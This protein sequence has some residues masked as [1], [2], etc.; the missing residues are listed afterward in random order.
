MSVGEFVGGEYVGRPGALIN[1]CLFKDMDA[2]SRQYFDLTD[3]R[4]HYYTDLLPPSSFTFW[5]LD[6]RHPGLQ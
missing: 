4:H 2:R 6:M 1:C 3:E 5:H